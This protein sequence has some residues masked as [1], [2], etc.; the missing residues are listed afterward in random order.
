MAEI[1]E[2]LKDYKNWLKIEAKGMKKVGELELATIVYNA[3][4][5]ELGNRISPDDILCAQLFENDWIVYCSGQVA[6]AKILSAST[7]TVHGKTYQMTEYSQKSIRISIHG[8]PLHIMDKEVESWVDT[9]AVRVTDVQKHD[10]MTKAKGES[11]FKKLLS[12]NRF[13]YASSIF[14]DIPRFTTYE[15]ADPMR[16]TDLITANVTI[17]FNDQT[18]NCKYCKEA[19][20]KIDSCPVIAAKKAKIKCFSCG[21]YG[22]LSSE[23]PATE[24]TYAFNGIKNKLSNFYQCEIQYKNVTHRSNEH[25]YQWRKAAF[26]QMPDIAEKISQADSAW[27]AKKLG[28]KVKTTP[29]WETNCER[30]MKE[31]IMLKLEQCSAFRE[32]LLNTGSKVLVECTRDRFWGAGL[33]REETLKSSPENW[34]GSNTMGKIL[35]KIRDCMTTNVHATSPALNPDIVQDYVTNPDNPGTSSAPVL[36]SDP[37]VNNKDNDHDSQALTSPG[38]A[39]SIEVNGV[40]PVENDSEGVNLALSLIDKMMEPN[41]GLSPEQ[42]EKVKKYL[43]KKELY[44]MSS[45]DASPSLKRKEVS[46]LS[47]QKPTKKEKNSKDK[48]TRV[49]STGGIKQFLTGKKKK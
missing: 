44:E 34:P 19:N 46:P 21:I 25:L 10:V 12:G 1:E 11:C 30:F 23:C 40:E 47:D 42:F 15:M 48:I 26:H 41:N 33:T 29:A 20:H 13:C 8:I 37:T 3:A 2:T 45:N 9:F 17:Y 28:D 24:N 16:P 38:Q 35:T 32:E 31:C 36:D 49:K 27:E 14:H 43:E 4:H 39:S 7:I 6:K 22:H 5:A 18:I